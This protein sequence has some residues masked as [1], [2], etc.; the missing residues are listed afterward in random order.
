MMSGASGHAVVASTLAFATT[1][2]A[3]GLPPESQ[4]TRGSVIYGADDRK[5][6][7]QV[8]DA[9]K[10][11]TI[12]NSVVALIPRALARIDDNGNFA[13]GA[14][15]LAVADNLCPGEPFATQPS[16]AF[17]TGV[18]VDWDLVLTAGHCGL[19]FL[20][21]DFV[22]VRGFF[23]DL[24]G[25]LAVSSADDIRDVD[26]IIDYALD[27]A[28]SD[29][30]LDF[31]W[32]RLKSTVRPPWR[33]APIRMQMPFV[34]DP[35]TAINT[36]GGVPLKL[37]D[38]AHIRSVREASLD[39]FVAD[40]DTLHGASGGGAFDA[41]LNLIGVLARGEPDLVPTG[42]GCNVNARVS[43]GTTA[44]E[45]YTYAFRAVEAL[46]DDAGPGSSSLCRLDCGDVC[47]ATMRPL[48][49]GCSVA[50]GPSTA[51]SVTCWLLLLA[52]STYRRAPGRTR[53]TENTPFARE[54]APRQPRTQR[55]ET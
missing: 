55:R 38:G 2:A 47:A 5:E 10:R 48:E 39:Y 27:S 12:D 40:T 30:R 23:Y 18:L 17:C 32:V 11:A 44:D 41:S 22:V 26:S 42:D 35:I 25:H 43:D 53:G 31:A 29:P 13:A 7:Y 1:L 51:A 3:C 20:P 4:L 28:G 8:G 24:P 46:C 9:D 45:E 52:A 36:G 14:P 16:V 15:S 50:L 19:V 54:N 49:G 34:G 37:D 6:G 21:Q 33:P